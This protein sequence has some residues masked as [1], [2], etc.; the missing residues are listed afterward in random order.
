MS[1]KAEPPENVPLY[2]E[3]LRPQFHFTS[4]TNWLNDPNGLVFYK[5]E[6]H[7]FFQHNPL[8]INWGNMTWGHAVSSDLLHWRQLDDAIAPDR[9]GTIFSGS[10]VIDWNNT[11]GLQTGTEKPLIAIFTSAGGTS[12]ESNKQPFTQSIAASNDRGRTFRKYDHN[13]V[14]GH[15]IGGN[16]DP[17]VIW[18]AASKKWVM[19]LYLDG[20]QYALFSSTDLKNWGAA[21]RYPIVWFGRMPR[22]VRAANRGRRREN[23]LDF[24]GWEQ[25]LFDRQ[26]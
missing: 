16:R 13:P 12:T 2:Q 3:S 4:R 26:L 22:P 7:L 19:A 5:G 14:L 10:A 20:D 23:A 6:Y 8:G 18:H 11:A 25:H 15:I 24:L 17:K 9:L 1:R 21:Q